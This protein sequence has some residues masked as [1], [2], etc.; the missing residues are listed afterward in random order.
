V[1]G[2]PDAWVVGAITPSSV[3]MEID[4]VRTLIEVHRDGDVHYVDS[5]AGSSVLHEVPRFPPPMAA[6]ASGSLLA[7]MPGS[8]VSVLVGA[9][10]TVVAGQAVAVLEAMKMQHTIR[11]PQDGVVADVRATAGDQVDGGTVL[12]VIEDG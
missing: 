9:G 7:P 5:P 4:G 3:E 11:A 12:L 10:D 1:I 2:T 6:A 8:V